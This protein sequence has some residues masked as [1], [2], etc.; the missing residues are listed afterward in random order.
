MIAVGL[1]IF[2]PP[3]LCTAYAGSAGSPLALPALVIGGPFVF[4]GGRIIWGGLRWL[5]ER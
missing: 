1:L 5:R 2:V 3:G 4:I